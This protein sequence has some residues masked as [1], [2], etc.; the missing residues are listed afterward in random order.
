M[1]AEKLKDALKNRWDK[2]CKN[3]ITSTQPL[4][5]ELDK[6]F[7]KFI[8]SVNFEI[9]DHIPPIKLIELHSLTPYHAQRFGTNIKKRPNFTKPPIK[10]VSNEIVYIKELLKAFSQASGEDVEV[11]SLSED[12]DYKSEYISA[13]KNFYA[14]EDLEKFSRDWLPSN[15]YGELIDECYESIS[16]TVRSQFENGYQRYLATNTH[17]SSINYTS[18]PLSPYIKAQDK[19]GMCHQLVNLN[20]I[21]WVKNG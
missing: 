9:F 21:K 14:A 3:K 7:V 13:R 10:P 2:D 12:S 6:D 20:R 11:E 18:H 4:G 16:S 8:D 17:V 19:K 5:I 1:N 15:S